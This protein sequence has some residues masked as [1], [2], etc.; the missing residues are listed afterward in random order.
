[1]PL[2][3][4]YIPSVSRSINPLPETSGGKE[5][6]LR[7][8]RLSLAT[9]AEEEGR[10]TERELRL[11]KRQKL[12]S[13]VS[14]PKKVRDPKVPKGRLRREIADEDGSDD[15]LELS[16]SGDEKFDA[17]RHEVSKSAGKLHSQ[18]FK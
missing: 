10:L 2:G 11:R 14:P 15:D 8:K 9:G 1:M 18:F 12:V 6:D 3:G 4:G 7:S 5:R 16:T 17:R 13:S